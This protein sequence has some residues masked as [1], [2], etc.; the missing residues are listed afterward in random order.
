MKESREKKE[1][2]ERDMKRRKVDANGDLNTTILSS[3][4]NSNNKSNKE[5]K[6]KKKKLYFDIMFNN[7]FILLK[8][9]TENENYDINHSYEVTHNLI[10]FLISFQKQFTV[11]GKNVASK[12]GIII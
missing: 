4:K 2:V 1:K 8:L 3:S 6:K 9:L 7:L 12:L 5:Q 11:G 10:R